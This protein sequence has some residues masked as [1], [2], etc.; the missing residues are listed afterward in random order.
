VIALDRKLILAIDFNNVLFGSYYG[1]KLI[2]SRGTNVNAIKGFFFKLKLLKDTLNPDYIVLANDVSRELTFRRRLYK[3]YKANRKPHDPDVINQLKLGVQIAGLAGFPFINNELYEADDI[4]GMIAKYAN[5]NEMDIIMLSS[6]KDLYQL[7]HEGVY[8]MA[9]GN[10][11][12]GEE[13]LMQQYRLT[14]DQWIEKKMLQGDR[15]DNIPG[16]DGVG[17]VTALRLLHEYHSIENIY[18]HL[19]LLKPSLRDVLR[20]GES[21][22]PLV[23]ELVTI[24]TD[25]TKINFEHDMMLPR[26]RFTNELF[27]LLG[28]LELPSLFNVFRYSLLQDKLKE[29]DVGRVA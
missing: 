2:N 11:V 25:H 1:E 14:P 10:E 17:E 9:K 6:D 18:Q 26:E 19:H 29:F 16:I 27:A 12:I 5:N 23:R 24:V 15:G 3:P 20:A 4:L 28:H 22:L 8:I 21:R 13:W 7:L